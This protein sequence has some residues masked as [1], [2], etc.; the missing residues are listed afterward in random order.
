[1]TQYNTWDEGAA[2]AL[3]HISIMASEFPHNTDT[4]S[5]VFESL[6]DYVRSDEK[7]LWG[8]GSATTLMERAGIAAYHLLGDAES[9]NLDDMC[10]LLVGKQH[11]YGHRNIL[12]FGLR[13]IAVRLCDKI[14]RMENLNKRNST[15][16]H[17]ALTDTHMDILGYSAIALMLE[18]GS[19]ELELKQDGTE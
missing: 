4:F 14:A 16:I 8:G 5:A 1:M 19:F 10:K 7:E 6:G 11:D 9:F 3:K 15:S 2:A 12:H 13:G 17:E 18:D